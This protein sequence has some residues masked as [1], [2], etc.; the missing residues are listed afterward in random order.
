LSKGYFAEAIPENRKG[1]ISEENSSV[2]PHGSIVRASVLLHTLNHGLVLSLP[3][4]FLAHGCEYRSR[5]FKH[6]IAHCSLF[7]HDDS[8]RIEDFL[9]LRRKAL[10]ATSSVKTKRATTIVVEITCI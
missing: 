4:R 9:E 3:L 8:C 6:E 1:M 7:F 5:L 2:M 10:Y